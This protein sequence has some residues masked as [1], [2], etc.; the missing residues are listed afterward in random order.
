MTNS[1]WFKNNLVAIIAVVLT[2]GSL[3]YGRIESN[4]RISYD[5]QKVMKYEEERQDLRDRLKTTEGEITT[6]RGFSLG[7]NKRLD[8][9]EATQNSMYTEQR[10]TNEAMKSM[11][12]ASKELSNSVKE[13]TKVVERVAVLE[14]RV[15][16][17]EDDT[18]NRLSP[19]R[20][21]E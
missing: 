14:K 9:L 20:A 15:E 11:A 1:T 3:V 2:C 13:L 21:K 10:V 4:T 16:V 12:E 8:N 19:Y 17:V 6:L 7:Y 5:V 18:R